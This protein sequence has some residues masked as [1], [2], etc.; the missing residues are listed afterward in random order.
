MK[1]LLNTPFEQRKAAVAC[2]AGC[3]HFTVP[4]SDKRDTGLLESC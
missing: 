3:T 4:L 2:P 1:E